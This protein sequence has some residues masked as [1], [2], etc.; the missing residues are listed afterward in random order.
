[1]EGRDVKQSPAARMALS[2]TPKGPALWLA[3]GMFALA[4]AFVLYAAFAPPSDAPSLVPWDKANHFIAFYVLTG[5]AAASFPRTGW[6][7]LA[8][9]L[10]A[11]GGA[12][13]LVQALPFVGRDGAVGDWVADGAGI[14]AVL[15][16]LA[17]A[18][19]RGQ[20]DE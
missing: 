15:G 18:W 9:G 13:E 19:W 16:P 7:L 12:I 6:I 2:I 10:L 5:L 14:A 20:A 8:A 11:L 17:L 1:M 4:T 3:R